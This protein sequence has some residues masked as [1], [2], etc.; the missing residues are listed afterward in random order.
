MSL[1]FTNSYTRHGAYSI[2]IL[3]L[4]YSLNATDKISL[5]YIKKKVV[6]LNKLEEVKAHSGL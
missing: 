3:N 2:R 4:C 5:P 6:V 1:V